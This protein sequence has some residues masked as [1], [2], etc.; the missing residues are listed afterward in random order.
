MSSLITIDAARLS[1][2][3]NHS[4]RFLILTMVQDWVFQENLSLLHFQEMDQ[5]TIARLEHACLELRDMIFA[6][7]VR[8]THLEGALQHA[9]DANFALAAANHAYFAA[10]RRRVRR[11]LTY[12][13]EVAI[14]DDTADEHSSGEQTE[15]EELP[16]EPEDAEL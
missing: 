14:L 7:D 12:E 11:R 13:E 9:E 2:N 8:I 1:R 3:F 15:L 6:R 16:S 10:A 4:E 5:N